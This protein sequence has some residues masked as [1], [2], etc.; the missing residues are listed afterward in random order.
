[1]AQ[2][3]SSTLT[4]AYYTFGS[5]G[6]YG[7][8][9]DNGQGS[10]G[11]T[12]YKSTNTLRF[13]QWRTD[14]ILQFAFTNDPGDGQWGYISIGGTK[15]LRTNATYGNNG[16]WDWTGVTSN[17]I[18][19]T[20]STDI[21]IGYEDPDFNVTSTDVSASYI[22]RTAPSSINVS[23][24]GIN[25]PSG[26]SL[27]AIGVGL[28]NTE[29]TLSGSDRELDKVG[30][31]TPFA[32]NFDNSSSRTLTIPSTEFPTN[33]G[34]TQN[35]YIYTARTGATN[36]AG[37]S[38]NEGTGAWVYTGNYV[39]I[40]KGSY[41][42]QTGYLYNFDTGDHSGFGNW[43]ISPGGGNEEGEVYDIFQN[44]FGRYADESG[45]KYWLS[46]RTRNS[47]AVTE[48][49]ILDAPEGFANW[50]DGVLNSTNDI[51]PYLNVN[52][53][54]SNTVL[55][56]TSTANVT[57]NVTGD[58]DSNTQYRLVVEETGRWADTY[59][60][61]GSSSTDF[62]LLY[63]DTVGSDLPP[64][65]T[66]WTYRLEARGYED[67]NGL[68]VRPSTW[69]DTGKS[70][71]ISRENIVDPDLSVSADPSIYFVPEGPVIQ[72]FSYSIDVTGCGDSV[73]QYSV[74]SLSNP[75]TPLT[76]VS[77]VD[78]NGT[79]IMTDRPSEGESRTYS[80]IARVP[81]SDGG[82]GEWYTTS[83]AFTVYS[84]YED[85]TNPDEPPPGTYGLQIY[86]EDG[87]IALTVT[88]DI[89]SFLGTVTISL[90]TSE[91][92]DTATVP[93]GTNRVAPTGA[94]PGFLFNT[95]QEVEP[96]VFRWSL[97]G[98][99]LTMTKV[100]DEEGI[101]PSISFSV[102][103]ICLDV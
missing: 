49:A 66:T 100:A 29:E 18:S 61:G 9:S 86:D 88:D 12:T 97:N 23:V 101:Y 46:F 63:D 15:F 78:G 37:G 34:N 83:G 92:S 44:G 77:T 50:Y 98:T 94:L 93:A 99:T 47:L 38:V 89:V 16:I 96:E 84:N 31:V 13:I 53:T 52:V 55:S 41:S 60:G 14:N 70:F 39:R 36:G 8:N 76:G 30:A 32:T 91:I 24:E 56:N 57:V 20:G 48:T 79:I 68:S 6:I 85:F 87:D 65:G 10:I 58:I 3:Y 67:D 69:T 33:P 19:T 95:S 4:A 42:I 54:P 21:R 59:N 74:A 43:V 51:P 102:E 75:N 82:S 5:I 35:I 27:N 40:R 45:F 2:H 7:W 64:A 62:T 103:F 22:F 25:A 26:F 90:G 17:P 1:M 71:T 81:V 72:P 80:I 73:S 11:S 28:G